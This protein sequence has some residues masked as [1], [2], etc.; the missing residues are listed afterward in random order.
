VGAALVALAASLAPRA[1]P[2][3]RPDSTGQAAD[4]AI[5]T[6]FNLDRLR[7]R[8][9]GVAVGLVKP[10]QMVSTEMYGIEADYG[11]IVP[12]VRVVFSA[13]FWG[14]HLNESTLRRYRNQLTQV[15]VDPTGDYQ[16]ALGNVRVSDIAL[17]MDGRWSPA[18]YRSTFLQPYA[19]GGLAAHV[20]NA[21]GRAIANTFVERALDNIAVAP[22]ALAGFDA[23]FFKQVAIGMQARYDL[24]NAARHGSLRVLGTYYFDHPSRTHRAEGR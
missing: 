24:V 7:F 6:R 14:S 4:P 19:G 11:E 15:I 18:R 20:L 2:A 16:V 8:G 5:D 12:R 10:S 3:Q 21:E 9:L 17:S 1:A 22:L 23:V 13:A